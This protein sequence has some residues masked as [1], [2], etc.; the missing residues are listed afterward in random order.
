MK[1][2]TRLA[3][4][5][6]KKNKTRSILI[7]LSIFLTTVLLSAIATFGY[8]N[9]K[10]Q[11]TN[12]REFYGS[13]YGSYAGVTEEQIQEMQKRSEF[14]RIG[15]AATVG[16]IKNE[17]TISMVW[18]DEETIDLANLQKQ[19]ETGAFPKA[20]NEIVGQKA[21]FERLGYEDAKVGDTVEIPFRRNTNETYQTK[22]F[23]I[24]GILSQTME[25]QEN[26]SYSAYVSKDC[27][28]SLYAPEERTYST[29]FSLSDH[30]SVDSS[31]LEMTIKDL[32]KECGINPECASENSYFAMWVLDPG[33]EMI[34]GCAMIALVVIFFAVMV[35][36]NIFQVGLVQKIQ[37]YGKI[38]A[39][40][41]TKKQMKKLVFREGMIL[42][43]L[44][45]TGRTCSR[46]VDFYRLYELL[47]QG[48]SDVWRWSAGQ[49]D[50]HS[51]SCTLCG[52]GSHH[53]L[54]CVET[55]YESDFQNL[56]GRGNPFP[57]KPEKE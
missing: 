38:R 6:N 5:N 2:I 40:G 43:I 16:T 48:E 26:Q 29:Y 54:D 55:S 57:G 13:Y 52:S 56:P 33:M 1:M 44:G 50:F 4:S 37:E 27:F 28:E 51:D 30:V 7:V 36:Y 47:V 53:C 10:F 14:D 15:R 11:R 12:A 20:E 42:T 22:E 32:A 46:D 34:A 8:G 3:I 24:S 39:L 25:E 21:M 35:I 49:Y 45:S 9:I 18:M 31:T 23:V 41:A 19:L 17:R